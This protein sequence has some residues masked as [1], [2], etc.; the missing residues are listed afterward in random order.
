[1]APK[2]RGQHG[3]KRRVSDV[4][5]LIRRHSATAR[6]M[7]EIRAVQ[8]RHGPH[9][10]DFRAC[11]AAITPG[12]GF[13]DVGANV[14]N[15]ALGAARRVGSSGTVIALEPNPAVYRELV[16]SIWGTNV[17]ALNL[18]ASDSSGIAAFQVPT[19]S[20]GRTE[21]PLG[22]LVTRKSAGAV[23]TLEVRTIRLDDIVPCGLRVAAVKID[24]EGHEMAVLRGAQET[25]DACRP[26]L[27]VEIEHRHLEGLSVDDV[28]AEIVE[29]GYTAF[30]IKEGRLMPFEHFDLKRDQLQWLMDGEGGS[31]TI[32]VVDEY[33]NNFVFYARG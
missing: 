21:P 1:M 23:K 10:H 29:H 27:V 32:R 11:M 33:V 17:V 20:E 7:G 31:T 30:A 9:S 22:S 8:L 19:D 12:T 3:S 2:G 16:A 4:G 24:V 15:Y 6:L 28:V 14:G 25:I 18:A 13:I 26:T 5:R